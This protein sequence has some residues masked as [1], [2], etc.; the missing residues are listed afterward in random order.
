MKQTRYDV[1]ADKED[2]KNSDD[3]QQYF[4]ERAAQI[5]L[6]SGM[7]QKHGCIIANQD[8]IISIGYNHSTMHMYHLFSMHAEVDALR[9]I[10][11]NVDLSNA[12]LYVVRIG[13][14]SL[15]HPLKMSKPCAACSEAIKKR[16]IGKVYYSW[17]SMVTS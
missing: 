3:R 15:G 8:G 9:K 14:A 11:K 16:G 12:E 2:P 10:K 1:D 17:S 13:P 5:A 7:G 6:K 4:L